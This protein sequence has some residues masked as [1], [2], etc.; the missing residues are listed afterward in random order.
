MAETG[1]LRAIS[2]ALLFLCGAQALSAQSDGPLSAIDWLSDSVAGPVASPAAPSLAEPPT[3]RS[4]LPE[5]VAVAPLEPVDPASAGI[6]RPEAVGLPRDLWAGAGGRRLAERLPADPSTLLPASR[7]LLATMV[8]VESEPPLSEGRLFLLARIDTLLALG[9]LGRAGRLM[10][11]AGLEDADIFRRWF[12][13]EILL[14]SGNRACARLRALPDIAPTYAARIFCLARGGD[15]SAAALTLES[16]RALE[17]LEEKEA[18]LLER[19]LEPQLAEAGAPLPL[20][21]RP[22]PL[23]F[24]MYEAIGQPISTATLPL[25]FAH[26]DLRPVTGWKARIEAAERLARAG[27]LAPDSLFSIYVERRPAA[28]GGVWERVAAIHALDNALRDETVLD[29]GPA[30]RTAWDEMRRSG[31]ALAFSEVYARRL[32]NLPRDSAPPD[33]VARIGLLSS[34]HARAADHLGTGAENAA[35]A[36]LARGTTPEPAPGPLYAALGRGFAAPQPKTP[37][38]SPGPAI[39]QALDRIEIGRAGNLGALSDGIARL[40]GLGLDE[41][42]RRAALQITLLDNVAGG[43]GR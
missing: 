34:H 8:A 14:N 9:D 16:A 35:L 40:R 12:D 1:A 25:A 38:E 36:A 31:L 39:L 13:T 18:V 27:V 33:L 22:T 21:E 28:S 19:F 17:V 20:P 26:A 42:A 4:A 2:A 7:D 3:A 43:G 6:L 11:A 10:E 24:A 23:T 32:L 5:P 15:W 29:V 30:L 41:T 37:A